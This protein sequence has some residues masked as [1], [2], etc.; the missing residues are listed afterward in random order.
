MMELAEDGFIV[1]EHGSI[2]KIQ[3][4]ILQNEGKFRRFF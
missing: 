3:K 4:S 1:D 2:S